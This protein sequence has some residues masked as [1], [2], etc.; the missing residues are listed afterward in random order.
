[1]KSTITNYSF[2][3]L[4]ILNEQMTPVDSGKSPA[5]LLLTRPPVIIISQILDADYSRDSSHGALVSQTGLR[6]NGPQQGLVQT[7]SPAP[8]ASLGDVT[9]Y[10]LICK[11]MYVLLSISLGV[12]CHNFCLS[13]TLVII[14]HLPLSSC[15]LYLRGLSLPLYFI[16]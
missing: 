6:W 4:K 7:L 12:L 3:V 11:L 2:S 1:M 5:C 8:A 9:V 13:R 14:S 16:L 15:P 10:N